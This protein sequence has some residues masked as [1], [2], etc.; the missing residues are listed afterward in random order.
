MQHKQN[1]KRNRKQEEKRILAKD[2]LINCTFLDHKGT[3]EDLIHRKQIIL[4]YC[5]KICSK[6]KSK[7]RYLR[8]WNIRAQSK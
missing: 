1:H 4:F 2:E 6:H 3:E 5:G 7:I 8:V